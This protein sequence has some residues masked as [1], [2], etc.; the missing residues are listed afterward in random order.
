MGLKGLQIKFFLAVTKGND[1]VRV[2]VIIS[3]AEYT[4]ST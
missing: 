3:L 2:T 4:P 1:E